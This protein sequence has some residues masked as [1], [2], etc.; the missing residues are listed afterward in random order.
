[1]RTLIATARSLLLLV[2]ITPVSSAISETIQLERQHGTDMVPVRINEAI[3]LPF[4]LDSGA[5]EVSIPTDVFLTLLRTGT[6]KS[7]DFLGKGRYVLADGSEHSSDRFMLHEVRVGDH[8]VR[9]VVAN[10]AP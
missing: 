5:A 6:I 8:V 9:N 1:M 7:S 2:L 10:V 3:T 4:V